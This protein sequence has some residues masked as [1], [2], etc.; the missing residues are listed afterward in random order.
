MSPRA[1]SSNFALT[2]RKAWDSTV[3]FVR[4]HPKATAVGVGVALG[5]VL[6]FQNTHSVKVHF[7]F[8]DLK[9]P[10]VIWT[11][12]FGGMGY[13]AGKGIE[14]ARQKHLNRRRRTLDRGGGGGGGA[15]PKK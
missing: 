3:F 15:P 2:L 7:F 11:V 1:G 5:L 12:F 8:W 14:W 10:M 9:F 6:T 4:T 13:L